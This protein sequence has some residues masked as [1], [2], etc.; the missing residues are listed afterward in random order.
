MD[1]MEQRCAPSSGPLRV[2]LHPFTRRESHTDSF[3]HSLCGPCAW[4]WIKKNSVSFLL[5]LGTSS[6]RD[7]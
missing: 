5:G 4:E 1:L 7:A 6:E 2:C 3:S